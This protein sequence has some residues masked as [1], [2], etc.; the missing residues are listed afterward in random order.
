MGK[1]A[2]RYDR[3]VDARGA[4]IGESIALSPSLFI[5]LPAEGMERRPREKELLET[6]CSK[7]GHR[8]ATWTHHQGGEA[9][10]YLE[11][12]CLIVG[13][14]DAGATPE[15]VSAAWAGFRTILARSLG[16]ARA[17]GN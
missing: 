8:L 6:I 17:E 4:Q 2:V 1:L 3:L 5:L 9:V 15:Q 11:C 10:T 7:C 14:R 16:Q 12:D 13:V